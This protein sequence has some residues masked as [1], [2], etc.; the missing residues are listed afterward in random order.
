MGVIFL[1]KNSSVFRTVLSIQHCH[2]NNTPHDISYIFNF[3]NFNFQDLFDNI[4][5][6][7]DNLIFYCLKI[8]LN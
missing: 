4:F 7:S 1:S 6:F 2:Q 3:P 8:A 5:Y